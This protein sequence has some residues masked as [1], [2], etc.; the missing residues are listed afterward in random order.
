MK[1]PW[2]L[3]VVGI[4]SLLWNA[5]GAFD[6]VM[7]QTRNESYMAEFTEDQLAFFYGFPTWVVAAWAVAVWLAVLG[8]VLL[9]LRKSAALWAFILSL[10]G[11]MLT[12]VYSY[13]LADVGMADLVGPAASLFSIAII[14]VGL[15]LVVYAR[16]MKL[17]GVLG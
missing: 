10:V 4:V 3:W 17:A 16:R 15:L 13:L 7:T 5:V 11:M 9:L 12:S 1:A 6:Y 2:H 8:S 14:V